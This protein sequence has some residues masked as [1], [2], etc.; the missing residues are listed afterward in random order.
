MWLKFAELILRNRKTFLW[1]IALTTLFMG[2]MGTKVEIF[3][4]FV[5]VVPADD[6]DFIQYQNFKKTF[7]EDGNAL[8]IGIEASH[9][10]FEPSFFYELKHLSDSLNKIEGVKRVLNYTNLPELY[11]NDSLQTFEIRPLYQDTIPFEKVKTKILQHPFYKNYIFDNSL[12]TTICALTL[13]DKILNSKEK[14]KLLWNSMKRFE[15]LAQKHGVKIHFAG[16]P[17]V[18][19]YNAQK[20]PQELGL[21]MVLATM[22]T[23]VTLFLFYRS[24]MPVVFPMLTIALTA[25][26]TL[27]LIALFGYKITILTA[28]LPPLLVIIGIPNSVYMMSDYHDEYVKLGNKEEALKAMIKKLGMVTLMINANTAFGFLTLYF[29]SVVVLQQF[30]IIAFLGTM[31]TYFLTIIM[32]PGIFSLLPDPTYQTT[33][34]LQAKRLNRFIETV[35]HWVKNH[36]KAI[37]ISSIT[38]TIFGMI[39]IFQLYAVSFMVDDLPEDSNIMQDLRFMEQ[40][41]NGVFPYEIIIDTQKKNGL[42][43]YNTLKK[44]EKLQTELEKLPE[45]SNGLSIINLLKL[46]RYAYFANQ[47]EQYVFPSKDEL[48][49]ITDYSRNSVNQSSNKILDALTDSLN[50]KARLQFYVKDLGSQQIPILFAKT[51]SI[52][53]SIFPKDGKIQIQITGTTKLF[54]KANEYLVDN[55]YWSLVA[56]FLIIGL[57]MFVL[58]WSWRIMLISLLVNLIPLIVTAGLMGYFHIPLKPSTALIYGIAFGIAIDNSIHLLAMYWN[59]RRHGESIS[60]AVYTSIKRTGMSIVYTSCILLAGFIIFTPSAFGSTRALGVLTSLTLFIALFSNLILLPALVEQWDVP[61]TKEELESGWINEEV[62]ED[63]E[64]VTEG[65]VNDSN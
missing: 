26:W 6:P 64:E 31:I 25:A 34:H 35:A 29:T 60:D 24:W 11:R 4:E 9:K 50:Q 54:L 5:K 61:S 41:F 63:I 59:R 13:T 36:K 47:P 55:L 10:L 40:K 27:G 32:M 43:N 42:K 14:H 49:F 23:A 48:A 19:T 22:V 15:E 44:I 17:Y 56:T 33:K 39:G 65:L 12:T 51:D 20:L 16:L 45:L 38:L 28:L 37:Y 46:S 58:F 8:I 2:Y 52:V 30:G 18:R 57:Q 7:G 53:Q 1:L 3:Q 21:F 62:D